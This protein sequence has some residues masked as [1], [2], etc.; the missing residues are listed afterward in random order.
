MTEFYSSVHQHKNNLLVLKYK[1]GKRVKETIPYRPYLFME[2]AEGD[3]K[4]VF[5]KPVKRIDFDSIWDAREFTK[6]YA[7]VDGMN[8]HGFANWAYQY[9]YHNF[10][11]NEYDRSLIRIMP[12]DIETDS[13][14]GFPNIETADKEVTM[15]T[16]GMNGKYYSMGVKDFDTTDH[17]NVTYYKCKDEVALLRKFLELWQF[18]GPDAV[19]GWN[20][21]GF[22]IP[23]LIRRITRILGEDQAKRLSPWGLIQTREVT[24]MYGTQTLYTIVGVADLDYQQLYIKFQIPLKGRP[25]SMSLDYVSHVEIGSNK[26]D[27]RAE[28]YK[29]L[30]DLYK[31]NPQLYA[32]YN[33]RDVSL[34]DDL[35]A[36]LKLIDIALAFAYRA[37]INYQDIYGT[38]RPWDVMIHKYLMDRKT[39][40]PYDK[41]TTKDFKIEGG[42]VKDPQCGLHRWTVSLDLTSLYPHVDIQYNIGPDSFVR[43]IEGVRADLIMDGTVDPSKLLNENEVLAANGCVY[44]TDKQSFIA[45]IMQMLFDERKLYKKKKLDAQQAKELAK[46]KEEIAQLVFEMSKFDNLQHSTKIFLNGGYG[47]LANVWNRWFDPDNAEAITQSGQLSIKWAERAVNKRMNKI[48]GTTDKDFVIAIDTDS[49]YVSLEM[50]ID[51]IYKDQ[52]DKNAIIKFMDKFVEDTLQPTIDKAYKELAA[53]MHA[54]VNKMEMKREALADVG[55]W[56]GKKHYILNVYNNE[57]VQYDTPQKKIVGIEA[58]RSSTPGAARSRIKDAIDLIVEGDQ[59]KLQA[60]VESVRDEFDELPVDEIAFPRS[61]SDIEKYSSKQTLFAKGC[62]IQAKACIFHNHL[63]RELKIKTFP[64]IKSGEKI[65]FVYL[66]EHNPYGISCVGFGSTLP[67]EFKLDDYVDRRKQFEKGFLEPIKSIVEIIGWKAEKTA[68]LDAFIV[69]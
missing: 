38:V 26:V 30:D 36:K 46:L 34:V 55:I 20:I 56:T 22:D 69:D 54:P 45:A 43:K 58:V 14:D 24:N 40:V 21:Q 4:T 64:L 63:L 27:F 23:Y 37:G 17:P 65:K 41:I 68:T 1:D 13:E 44:R 31:R 51:A 16:I 8:I 61:V 33:V 25:E 42:Y 2:N 60:Y 19:T 57:G 35:D 39:V 50:L 6:K 29:S 11:I 28:G 47:A 5:G 52:S 15:I 53:H 59:Y 3:Y 67:P 9:I 32:V 49:L 62:P 7:G 12:L 48:L 10:K 66:N 18:L